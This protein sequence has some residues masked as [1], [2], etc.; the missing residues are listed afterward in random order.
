[1]NILMHDDELLN[2]DLHLVPGRGNSPDDFDDEIP[3]RGEDDGSYGLDDE[4]QDEDF[5]ED[6]DEDI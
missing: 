6:E 2:L 3:R 5:L 4:E 1:M